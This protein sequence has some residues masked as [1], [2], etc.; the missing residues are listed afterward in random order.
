MQP[1]TQ[2]DLRRADSKVGDRV[3]VIDAVRPPE[4]PA[5]SGAQACLELLEGVNDALAG[6]ITSAQAM[7]WK[8]PSYSRSRRYVHEIERNALR[9]GELVKRLLKL[10]NAP[11][12]AGDSQGLAT[13]HTK[14]PPPEV[15]VLT[16]SQESCV[17]PECREP[18]VPPVGAAAA[19]AFYRPV[20][21]VETCSH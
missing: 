18:A 4:T 5:P 3:M 1:Q 14:V 6:V 9:G 21:E 20:K 11:G 7:E 8:L 12:P 15:L 17:A 19:P 13:N 10:L 2:K 16:A